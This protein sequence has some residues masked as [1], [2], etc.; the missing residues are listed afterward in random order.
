MERRGWMSPMTLLA[1]ALS[2]WM[3]AVFISCCSSRVTPYPASWPKLPAPTRGCHSLSGFYIESWPRVSFAS[4][5]YDESRYGCEP[6]G[7][8]RNSQSAIHPDVQ[9]CACVLEINQINCDSATYNVF[10]PQGR[11]LKSG[12]FDLSV[13][14]D[15]AIVTEWNRRYTELWGVNK[16]YYEYYAVDA[17]TLA[18]KSGELLIG[19]SYVIVPPYYEREEDWRILKR[20]RSMP[21]IDELRER[22]FKY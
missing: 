8:P 17:E 12:N 6:D 9:K 21:S 22:C 15:G 20:T 19:V 16:S 4:L 14:S 1:R 3:I 18:E 11:V 10:S 13:T 5:N 2:W 7:T